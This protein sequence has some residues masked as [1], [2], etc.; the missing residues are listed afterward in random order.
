MDADRPQIARLGSRQ[1]SILRSMGGAV[2][3]AVPVLFLLLFLAYPLARI[4]GVGLDPLAVEGPGAL[5]RIAEETGLGGLLASSALQALLST[6]LTLALGLPAAWVFSRFDF[7]GKSA[8]R[9]LLMIPFVLPTVV[10]ASAFVVLLGPG[11]FLEKG[12]MLLTANP[13][14]KSALGRGLAA[15]LA[16]HVF[17]NIAIVARIVGGSWSSLDTRMQEA[18]RVLGA[19]RLACFLRVTL[20][21]L[22]PS[23]AASGVLVFAFCFSSFGVILLLGGPRMGT[24]ETEI[25]RQAVYLFH[26]PSAALLAAVQLAATALV[27]FGYARLQ[28]RMSVIQNVRPEVRQRKPKSA[29]QVALVLLFGIGPAVA[30]AL[31]MAALL[32]GSFLARGGPSLGYWWALFRSTGHSLFWASPLRAIGN[33]LMFSVEAMLVSLLLGIPAAYLISHGQAARGRATHIGASTLDI[34]FLLPLGTSAVTLGF[35]FIVA[36]SSP[37]LNMRSSVFLIPIAHALVAL[38]LVVRSLLAPLRSINPR[39]R[40]AASVLGA[41]PLRVRIEI[42]LALL[43]RAFIAAAAFAFTVSLGEFGAT[44]LLTRPELM[45]LPVLVYSSLSRPGEVSRG[46]ALALST[47]LMAACAGGLAVIER[48]RTRGTEVF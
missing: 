41:P 37:P 47:L 6:V 15:V 16:A 34:L 23:I 25:Y 33:S 14:A 36:L 44:A 7:P 12:I 2:F 38:P 22:L 32:L 39:M 24:L 27:M 28:A 11:G 31:P 48:L 45:T 19:G 9:T 17:Y 4:L 30:L 8:L 1:G 21:L 26:L 10:V 5:R 40:E 20:R 29:A 46:Q 35:G 3:G 18:A 43:R 13:N 42:D